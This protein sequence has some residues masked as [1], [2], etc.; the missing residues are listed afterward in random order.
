MLQ[1]FGLIKNKDSK[2]PKSCYIN[3]I[4]FSP[5]LFIQQL[6]CTKHVFFMFLFFQMTQTEIL[7]T[8]SA[9]IA[10]NIGCVF[11]KMTPMSNLNT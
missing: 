3:V 11:C 7:I 8:K 9:S 2:I 1:N 10:A 6:G 4:F 5:F